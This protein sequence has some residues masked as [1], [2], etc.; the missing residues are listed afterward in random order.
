MPLG[1]PPSE[2]RTTLLHLVPH[3]VPPMIAP[4][5]KTA[6]P[7]PIPNHISSIHEHGFYVSPHA[8]CEWCILCT[9]SFVKKHLFTNFHQCTTVRTFT[10]FW[11]A[12]GNLLLHGG[13]KSS[14][15]MNAIHEAVGTSAATVLGILGGHA[16]I[17][18]LAAHPEH[19]IWLSLRSTSPA[20]LGWVSTS[21]GRPVCDVSSM[22]LFKQR[23][24]GWS[25][26]EPLRKAIASAI[27]ACD[28]LAP[29]II[30]A[31]YENKP[32]VFELQVKRNNGKL[33]IQ[34]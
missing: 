4:L 31:R 22:W 15:S 19:P 2:F 3:F 32:S 10:S 6:R 11:Q 24:Y 23:L 8:H 1:S 12:L 16:N 25:S 21:K 26:Q 7:R 27:S 29:G 13:L 34:N 28:L 20:Y 30:R 5:K 18:I 9:G 33:T 14:S 17:C